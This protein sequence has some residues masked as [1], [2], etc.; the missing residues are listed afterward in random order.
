MSMESELH[1]QGLSSLSTDFHDELRTYRP[2]RFAITRLDC[3]EL[4]LFDPSGTLIGIG[5]IHELDAL[6]LTGAEV[7]DQ[8]ID[9][10][11]GK[12]KPTAASHD[13][14]ATLNLLPP[15]PPPLKRRI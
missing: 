12:G 8:C 4:A 6:I 5:Q 15:P 2:H 10:W 13:L 7:Y 1:S 11:V 14:L 9:R 3:G